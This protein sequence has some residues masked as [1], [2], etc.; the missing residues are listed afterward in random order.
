[1]SLTLP[2]K[3]RFDDRGLV[4]AVAQDWAT[5]TVLLV[6][7]MNREA[8]ERT[9]A[10]GEAHFWSRSRQ[11]LWHKGETSG[12]VLVVERLQVDC[13]DDALLLS[14]RPQGPACHLGRRSCFAGPATLTDQL[15]V[16]L[17]SRRDDP[18]EGS[19]AAELLQQG[20]PAI[21]RKVG[22]E[23]TEVILAAHQDDR[24]QLVGEIADV[25]FHTLVLL[26]AKGLK[27]DDVL[28]ELA[29]RVGRP[30]RSPGS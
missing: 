5:G 12:A 2:A 6:A 22:E 9:A 29:A 19:Y 28:R 24:R 13:D 27:G 18:P 16:T 21:C 8:L 20:V 7:Y 26:V 14:V 30:R 4:V 23:A 15:Q 25:W 17:E 1:M 3:V 11:R 10:T